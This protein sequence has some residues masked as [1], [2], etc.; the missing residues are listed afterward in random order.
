MIPQKR[1]GMLRLISN[2]LG[3]WHLVGLEFYL[4][5]WIQFWGSQPASPK[6]WCLQDKLVTQFSNTRPVIVMHV[7]EPRVHC[8][9][10]WSHYGSENLILEPTAVSSKVT[11]D[12]DKEMPPQIIKTLCQTSQAKRCRQTTLL[13]SSVTT[14]TCAQCKPAVIP[15]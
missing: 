8:T 6:L 3:L 13:Y 10:I 9:S 7:K 1:P 15:V 4:L 11:V 2:P 12:Y 5:N 14:V